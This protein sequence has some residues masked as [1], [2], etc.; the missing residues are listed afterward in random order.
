[1]RGDQRGGFGTM[2]AAGAGVL[3]LLLAAP[4]VAQV[5]DPGRVPAV[6]PADDS[7]HALVRAARSA[8]ERGDHRTAAARYGEAARLAPSIA[9]WLSL[10]RLQAGARAGDTAAVRAL[11][12]ELSGEPAIPGD[13]VRLERA[14]AAF[15]AGDTRRGLE[16]AR[17]LPGSAD[18]VLWTDRVAPALLAAGD[19]AAAREALLQAAR[20]GGAP[21][22]AGERLLELAPASTTLLYLARADRSAGRLARARRLLGRLM[23]GSDAYLRA[24]A[25]STLADLEMDAGR[26]ARAHEVADQGI[27]TTPSGPERARLELIAASTH[28]RRGQYDQALVH[29]RRGAEAGGGELSARA[30]YLSADLAHDRGRI[31][32]ARDR[33]RAA[34]ERFPGTAHGGQAR[35]RLGFL[36]FSEGDAEAA[37]EHFR[38]YR[39]TLP[40]GDW[41][42]ASLYWEGR[43]REREGAR[44]EARD[45]YESVLRT[46]PLSWYGIRAADRLGRD[47]VVVAVDEEPS[48]FPAATAGSRAA[49]PGAGADSTAREL[50]RR[51]DVLRDLD[52]R[53]RAL[54]ELDATRDRRASEWDLAAVAH[55]LAEDGWALPAI[56]LGWSGFSRNRGR[57]TRPLVEAVWPLPYRDELQGAARLLDLPPALVAGVVRQESAFDPAAVSGAGAIGL[58]QLMPATAAQLARSRGE[59][60]PDSEALTDPERNLGLGVLYLSRLVERF[61]DSG[62][63][64]VASYNAGPHRWDRWRG[65]PEARMDEEL[66][67]ERIPFR[68][69]RLYVKLVLRNAD[70]YARLYGL[71][72]AGWSGGL[73]SDA[74]RVSRRGSVDRPADRK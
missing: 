5:G 2:T 69:T 19:T 47:P 48:G 38:T 12:R 4:A 39:E 29:Y 57:W 63:G 53:D 71:E 28:A 44:A 16:V 37:A 60:P 56:R 9:P 64:V 65:L 7:L 51:M 26:L 32:T 11:A 68:E 31:E 24:R 18:P 14:R 15:V 72:A 42:T 1:M 27:R 33:Y 25:A 49:G 66:M 34:A 62:I 36:A 74:L 52:W 8:S 43:A 50:L 35:M 45:L 3:A 10:S 61:P 46:D 54:A 55:R 6:P 20:S 17:G 21:A 22:R 40:D 41:S 13:S 67:I 73:P 23:E 70:L 30:A 59:A 58:M